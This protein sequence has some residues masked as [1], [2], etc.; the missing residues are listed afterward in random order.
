MDPNPF[1]S[2]T[3][4]FLRG[5]CRRGPLCGGAQN[6]LSVLLWVLRGRGRPPKFSREALI[7][8]SDYLATQ[9]DVIKSHLP[10][11]RSIL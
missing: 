4:G 6:P 8:K 10:K 5:D 1:P 7:V 9:R 11:E 2:G 3:D